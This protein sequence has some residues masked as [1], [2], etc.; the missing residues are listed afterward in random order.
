MLMH[1]EI[2][3]KRMRLYYGNKIFDRYYPVGVSRKEID[4]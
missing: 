4:K 1:Y 3:S 2:Y